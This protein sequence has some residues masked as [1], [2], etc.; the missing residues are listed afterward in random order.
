MAERAAAS[1]ADQVIL[2]LEDAVAPADKAAAR[3]G[4]VESLRGLDFGRA[5]RSVRVNDV[6]SPWCEDDLAALIVGAGDALDVVVVPKVSGPEHVRFVESRLPPHVA[7]DVQ[8]ESAAGA[9][10][11]REISQASPRIA[12][13]VFGAGDYAARLGIAQTVIGAID[14]RA[15][16]YQWHWVMSQIA[17]CAH[18]V[19]AHR[20]RVRRLRRR[21]GLPRGGRGGAG[22][23]TPTAK[24]ASAPLRTAGRC[25]TRRPAAETEAP[26]GRRAAARDLD[27]HAVERRDVE[28]QPVEAETEA[29]GRYPE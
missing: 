24:P 6:E 9:V 25:S 23:S 10:N 1:G 21:A 12:A 2:D 18:A 5:V 16:D 29:L 4:A 11:V 13:L 3:A 20:R 26:A 28:L 19:G 27:H 14:R 22:C 7:L 17:A 15:H 8:I